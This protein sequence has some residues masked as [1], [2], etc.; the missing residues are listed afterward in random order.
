MNPEQGPTKAETHWSDH[1]GVYGVVA[2][3]P[4][5]GPI[6]MEQEGLHSSYESAHES[7][8]K[9]G[10]AIR[11]AVVRLTYI[12]GNEMLIHDMKRMQK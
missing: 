6:L 1:D 4:N 7:A 3:F 9:L 12:G 5:Q 8:R 2:E 10:T 11:W